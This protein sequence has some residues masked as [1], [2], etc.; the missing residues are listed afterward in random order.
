[1]PFPKSFGY[2]PDLPNQGSRHQTP[3]SLMIDS[4]YARLQIV[5]RWSWERYARLCQFLRMTE[6]EVGSMVMLTHS[7]VDTYRADK[8]RNAITHQCRRMKTIAL[9]TGELLMVDDQD[10]E[11]CARMKWYRKVSCSGNIYAIANL[12]R[13]NGVGGRIYAHRLIC[14]APRGFEVDHR[15]GNGLNCQRD[16][17]RLAT[18]TTNARAFRRKRKGTASRFRGVSWCRIR[19]MWRARIE[20]TNA[21]GSRFSQCG[22]Y[23]A[24]EE[25]AARA[26]NAKAIK[27]GFAPEALNQV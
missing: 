1:M 8:S 3:A 26:Y 27:F 12:P 10:Y 14:Q 7:A 9:K 15:D 16:N 21:D 23:Y 13:V 2:I 11:R 20:F 17:L 6:Y 25:R 22:G 24:E 19:K 4:R 18:A 5:E